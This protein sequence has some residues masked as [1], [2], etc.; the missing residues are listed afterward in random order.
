MN[1]IYLKESAGHVLANLRLLLALVHKGVK[2]RPEGWQSGVQEGEGLLDLE[3]REEGAQ[4]EPG[5]LH[6]LLGW[7]ALSQEVVGELRLYPR[8]V[9]KDG[10]RE[11]VGVDRTGGGMDK[12]LRKEKGER[13]TERR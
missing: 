13:W 8:I 4:D 2:E 11:R 12:N 10:T 1:R 5:H 9:M 3:V 7:R 6:P